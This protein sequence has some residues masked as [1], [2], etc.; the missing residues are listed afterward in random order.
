MKEKDFLYFQKFFKKYAK[1]YYSSDP[2]IHENIVLKEEHTYRVL[3]ASNT[4]SRSLKFSGKDKLIA[5]TAALFHDIGRFE[6]F[7]SYR[8]FDDK[9]SENHAKL[10]AKILEEE[11]VF[12]ILEEEDKKLLLDVI[13]HHNSYI[14]P[15][16]R[17]HN[18]M[19][20]SKVL[21]DADKLDILKVLTDYY[22]KIENEDNPVLEHNLSDEKVYSPE[23]IKDIFNK[24]NSDKSILKT[25]YDMRLFVLTWI[26]DVNYPVTL[27][28]IQERKY[29]DKILRVLPDNHDMKM[30]RDT[31]NN[32][33]ENRG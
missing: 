2:I 17:S 12:D 31:L 4:I 20:Q 24:K 3:Q 16:D 5:A 15:D 25:K 22:D 33:M 28:L 11:K 27:K 9:V 18:F 26:F 1:E 29:I 8:T 13:S 30:V 23:I 32:Y 19:I 7:K 10:S 6:Q 14:L 21:R